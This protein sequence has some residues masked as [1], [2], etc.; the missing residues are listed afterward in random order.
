MVAKWRSPQ[1]PVRTILDTDPIT[2]KDG[3]PSKQYSSDSTLVSHLPVAS[4]YM[5]TS[6]MPTEWKPGSATM[7]LSAWKGTNLGSLKHTTHPSDSPP[8]CGLSRKVTAIP[9]CRAVNYEVIQLRTPDTSTPQERT[10]H[11]SWLTIT[12]STRC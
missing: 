5:R 2:V 10:L 12:V 4:Q 8:F 3:R 11:S 9:H 7:P 6:Q 1:L